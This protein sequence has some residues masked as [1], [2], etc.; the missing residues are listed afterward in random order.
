MPADR[1]T[2]SIDESLGVA[3]RAA[4]EQRGSSIS[5]WFAE[6]A[7]DRLRNELLDGALSTYESEHGAFT[8]AELEEARAALGARSGKRRRV[9]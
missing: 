3:I 6:A 9:A 4:A 5:Q 1:I 8:H 7:A 2:L